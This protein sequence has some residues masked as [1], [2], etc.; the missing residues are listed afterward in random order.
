MQ[1]TGGSKP[2][3]FENGDVI[4]FDL[5]TG[6]QKFTSLTDKT[7]GFSDKVVF[8]SSTGQDVHLDGATGSYTFRGRFTGN[9]N[10]LVDAAAQTLTLTNRSTSTG[11]LALTNGAKVV[12]TPTGSWAGRISP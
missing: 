12:F 7:A 2:A 9:V 6:S 4:T 3:I 1:P 8:T 10:L 5:V 11:T